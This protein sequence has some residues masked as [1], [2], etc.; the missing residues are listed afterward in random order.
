MSIEEELDAGHEPVDPELLELFEILDFVEEAKRVRGRGAVAAPLGFVTRAQ[1]GARRPKSISRSIWPSRGGVALHY[2]GPKMGD[3]PHTSCASKVRGIQ[4]FHMDS[5]GWSDIAYS[6]LV[7]P[8][9][10]LYE[11]RWIG[12]RTAANGTNDGN[13]RYYAICGL[14]GVDDP[15]TDDAKRA[16]LTGIDLLR[17]SGA[18]R[19]VK[20]HRFFKPTGCPGEPVVS[21]INMGLPRPNDPAPTPTP[22]PPSG[23][24]RQKVMMKP[25]LQVGSSGQD[26]KILQALMIAHA[27]DLVA[28]FMGGWD[29]V[30]AFVDGGFGDR[31]RTVL[32]EWQKRTQTLTADGICG[33]NTWAWLVGV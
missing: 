33:P 24:F 28:W 13:D 10:A 9:G 17:E 26:V 21:W 23:D 3:F 5:R 31:T 11:G 1:W 7:C 15:F 6:A 16:Y 18:A 25:T 32:Y 4:A 30:H 12:V 19:D 8:H 2:E 27:P 29:K 22:E 20:P 14:F